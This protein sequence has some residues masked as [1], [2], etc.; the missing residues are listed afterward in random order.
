VFL[1]HYAVALA[2]KNA[3]P[4]TSLGVLFAAAQLADLL[5]PVFLLSGIERVRIAPGDTA[6]TP[7]AFEY[8]PWTHSLA[9]AVAWGVALAI[10]YGLLS[11]DRR[12]SLVVGALVVSHWVLDFITHRPDL[13]LIPGGELTVGLGLWRSVPWTTAVEVAMLAGGVWLYTR[14]TRSR[15]GRGRHGFSALVLVLLAIHV[16]NLIGPPPA[17]AR[18]LAFVAMAAA[19]FPVWAWWVDRH[20]EAVPR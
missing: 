3:A 1:G 10:G 6:V 4:R 14:S 20:R 18:Q 11:G 16:A 9:M 8:Y 12:G 13:P 2:A 19:V 5:W 7:L 15:D 17:H